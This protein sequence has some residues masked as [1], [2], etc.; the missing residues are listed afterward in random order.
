MPYL[1]G[2]L[3]EFIITCHAGFEEYTEEEA[4]ELGCFVK[5]RREGRVIVEGGLDRMYALNKFARTAHK[6]ILLLDR[7]RARGLNEI[8]S[9]VKAVDFSFIM[10][11][12]KFAVRSERSGLHDFTSLDIARVAGQA[13]IDSYLQDRGVRLGVDLDEPD[14]VITVDLIGEELFIGLDTTGESLHIREYRRYNHPSALKPSLASALIMMAGWRG[15]SLLDPFTG[16]ATIPIEAALM[17]K[18]RPLHERKRYLYRNLSFYSMDEEA[19][20]VGTPPFKCSRIVGV[21]KVFKHYRGAT[22]NVREAGVSDV[23]ELLHEDTIQYRPEEPFDFIVS[24]P[25]YGIRSGRRDKVQ[26]L[27]RLFADR[28]PRLLKE[29]GVAVLISTEHKPL[30]E[31]LEER[32]YRILKENSGRH[33]KLWV[34]ALKFT[35]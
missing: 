27:Y 28:L 15:G 6:V 3:N 33:G 14:V 11:E 12:Q 31:I 23:V 1:I 2:A 7:A 25:P 8:Y 26:V 4:R 32:G 19:R 5:E 35:G 16:G 10:P 9:R 20:V 17:A 21:E 34:K 30:K 29:G 22:K 18:G 24:N 13:V